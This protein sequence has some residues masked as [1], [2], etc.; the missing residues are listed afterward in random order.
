MNRELVNFMNNKDI[1][2]DEELQKL[3]IKNVNISNIRTNEKG[4]Y[5]NLKI[6][7][8]NFNKEIKDLFISSKFFLKNNISTNNQKIIIKSK[9]IVYFIIYPFAILSVAFIFATIFKFI[10]NLQSL[11]NFNY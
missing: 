11:F 4:L 6:D 10:P 9:F 1:Q 2:K 7:D 8:S 3:N 5:F